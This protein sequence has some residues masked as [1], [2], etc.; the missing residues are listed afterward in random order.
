MNLHKLVLISLLVLTVSTA[1]L[2]AD[3]SLNRPEATVDLASTAGVALVKGEWRYSD[4]KIVEADFR[5]PGPDKQ[6]TG[7]P[8]KTYDYTPHAGGADFDDSKWEVISPTSLDQRRGNGR[9]GFNWYR[10]KLTIPERVGDFDPTGSTAVFQTSLDDYAEIWVDGELSRSLGQS[11]GSVIA[12]WN[13]QNNLI[14]GRNVKPGQQIQLAIFGVNGPLSNPPT[15]FIY[16]R[17]ARLAFY[18]T[19]PGPVALT[20]SE[21]NVEVVRNDPAMDEIIGPNPKVFKLAE[22][23]KFTEGPI[24]VNRDGG[25]LLFS[26]PNAN[27]IYKYKPN[28]N[29]DGKLDV[30]RTPSGYSGADIAEY[31]QPGSNGLTL[32]P[33]GRLTINQHGNHRVVRDENDGTQTV[34]ADRFQGK[35]LNSP[36]DLVYRSDGTL[37]FS[38]PP[39]GFP[40]LFNDPRKQ[41]PF[42]G[43]YSIYKGKLQLVSRDL[44]GPNGIALS[45]DEKYLYVGNWPRSLTGQELRKEDEP[46][47]E[48]GDRHKAIMR[49]EVQPDG[50][51]KNGKLFFDFTNASGEDGLDGI[52]VDRKGN[53]YVS[54]PGGLWVISPEGKHL[55]TIITP[56]HVHN[57]AWGDAD[58]KTLFLC[59]RSGLYRVRLNIPG[60]RPGLMDAPTKPSIVR[61]DPQLDQ[62]VPDD[63]ALE[64]VA[65]GFSWAEGPVW[66]R[67]G[68]Y[69]L[70]SDVPNNR[71]VKWKAG[72]A[73][74]VFLQRSGYSG[75]IPFTGR[76]P[77]SNGLTFDKEGRLVFCQHGDRRISRL[78]KNGTRTTLVDNY[79]G[80]RLNSPNDLIFKSNGDLYFTDPPFGLPKTFDDPQKELSFQGVY[81]LSRDGKLTLLTTEVKAPNGIAFSP[82]EKHLYVADSARAVWFVFDV[83]KDGTLSPARVL[84]DGAE[85][86]KGRPGVAD[87]LKVDV[88]GN[89]YAAAPGGLLIL[90]PDGKLLGRFDLGTA[91]GNCAW[92]EDGSTLFITSNSRLY[93]IR[94]RTRGVGTTVQGFKRLGEVKLFTFTNGRQGGL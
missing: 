60:V 51:L 54:A 44:T 55:G 40:K 24:W 83:K 68:N 89:I 31:G 93:R 48:I 53:L 69:L 85:E 23:F 25:Y 21:V 3:V 92:G 63:A 9:L 75:T 42:S 8:V 32:D 6:P 70:F 5:G 7:A 45:P 30:F 13:A 88:F 15:N 72:E 46:V 37:F 57:M 36:N 71:I 79:Q 59:A 16:V 18:K 78:E 19:E 34:L 62:I 39:F 29:D 90:A 43:V 73:A 41:L 86:S 52:K 66:S 84:Y 33:Q 12:G 87:S 28:G 27:T 76:E 74:S 61:L 47:S 81:R 10:I 56:R 1:K 11:G 4:T 80:K 50:T 77:G 49:Y 20:P 91:T 65:D 26:D 17:Y 82:D 14:V 58:G 35:R 64:K 22:G 94:L 2:S 38:D 67:A